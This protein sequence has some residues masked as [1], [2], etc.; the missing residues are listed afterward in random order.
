MWFKVVPEGGTS[1]HRSP[2]GSVRVSIGFAGLFGRWDGVVRCLRSERRFWQAAVRLLPFVLGLLG[3]P[4]EP[5]RFRAPMKLPL[6][7][8]D[9]ELRYEMLLPNPVRDN[10]S[11]L[12]DRLFDKGLKSSL[13]TVCCLVTKN[14]SERES[15]ERA[16]LR[17][18]LYRVNDD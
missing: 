12:R 7:Q 1:N 16:I 13:V 18:F 4:R 8:A 10:F 2:C 9:L 5:E 15:D 6:K 17:S 3:L 14:G 11:R